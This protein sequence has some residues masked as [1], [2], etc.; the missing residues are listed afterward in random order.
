M[1][2]L[3][4][5]D[6][7][8]FGQYPK[9]EPINLQQ[10]Q[11]DVHGKEYFEEPRFAWSELFGD[12]NIFSFSSSSVFVYYFGI[13]I[14]AAA[15]HVINVSPKRYANLIPTDDAIIKKGKSKANLTEK[16]DRG[17][18][19]AVRGGEVNVVITQDEEDAADFGAS[20]K[21]DCIVVHKLKLQGEVGRQSRQGMMRQKDRSP[22]LRYAEAGNKV[23][24]LVDQY[25]D[26]EVIGLGHV[27]KEPSLR[28]A[29]DGGVRRSGNVPR[30]KSSEAHV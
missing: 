18:R 3:P 9:N 17:P 20:A 11:K 25:S 26:V 21:K 16:N 6:F 10:S 29:R 15:K 8:N 22:M 7:H 5:Q 1:S 2:Q 30:G 14:L 4:R 27:A 28:G 13:T 24:R 23:K 19:C 12:A